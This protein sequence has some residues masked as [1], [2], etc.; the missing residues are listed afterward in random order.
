MR[1]IGGM[2]KIGNTLRN[3]GMVHCARNPC[4]LNK[5]QSF[6]H[7]YSYFFC[8]TGSF[9]GESVETDKYLKHL[10]VAMF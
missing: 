9:F 4:D 10:T 3:K 8:S 1:A 6:F 2:I 7:E 5:T